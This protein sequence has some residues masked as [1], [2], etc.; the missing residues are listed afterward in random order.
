M[1]GNLS[2]FAE[3]G[4]SQPVNEVSWNDAR[5]FIRRLNELTGESYRLP[6]EAEW[7]YAARS[8][9]LDQTYAGGEDLDE[10]GWHMGNSGGRPHPVG[11]KKPNG[12]GIF[13]MSGNVREW[14]EDEW[15]DS[16]ESAPSDSRAWV[17]DPR[18]TFRVVRGGSWKGIAR[19]C[20]SAYR[21]SNEPGYRDFDLGFRL[22]RSL[23]E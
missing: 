13:D 8:G 14:V 4:S 3:D 20:R 10:L 17:D 23:E 9:G 19:Y 1:G 11:Q 21:T 15:H 22:A 5:E 7:E 12:L 2:H 16:Y 18:G 6:S